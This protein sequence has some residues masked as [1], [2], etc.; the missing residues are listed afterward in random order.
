[1]DAKKKNV[2]VPEAG[3]VVAGLGPELA[4]VGTGVGRREGVP[5][6]PHALGE[7]VGDGRRA[8]AARV[9]GPARRAHLVGGGQS[10]HARHAV[11]DAHKEVGRHAVTGQ[12]ERAPLLGG[13]R[14]G[15]GHHAGGLPHV[16]HRHGVRATVHDGVVVQP[17]PR[18]R[19]WDAP[20]LAEVEV[21]VVLEVRRRRHGVVIGLT[22]MPPAPACLA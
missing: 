22:E 5:L 7:E 3:V 11:L 4:E 20:R 16:H 14:H 9:P 8:V 15:C 21:A 13:S 2:Y 1:M 6:G 10:E 18:V 12:Q 17:R 19:L